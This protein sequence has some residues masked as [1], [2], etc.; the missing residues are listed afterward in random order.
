MLNQQISLF[1]IGDEEGIA[2]AFS[3]CSK[4]SGRTPKKNSTVIKSS[5]P[6]QA[7]VTSKTHFSY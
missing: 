7:T 1:F 5:V 2:F 6:K 4:Q 3:Y